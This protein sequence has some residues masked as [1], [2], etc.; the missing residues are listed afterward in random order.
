MFYKN[1]IFY[2]FLFI[3]ILLYFYYY[4]YSYD[5]IYDINNIN[6][7]INSRKKEII[8]V[9]NYD[10]T[11]YYNILN[12]DECNHIINYSKN[13]LTDSKVFMSD[14][15]EGSIATDIRISKNTFL[16]PNII[17]NN[18]LINT[19]NKLE[20][21]TSV[22]TNLPIVNQENIQVVKYDKNGYYNPHYDAC[23]SNDFDDKLNMNR[24]AGQRIYTFLVY[25]ND[26]FEGGNTFFPKINKNVKPVKGMG[27]L[28]KNINDDENY[29]ILSQHTGTVIKKGN[30]WVCNIWVHQNNFKNSH[31]VNLCYCPNCN[32]TNCYNV[33]KLKGITTCTLEHCININCPNY[34]KKNF[35]C[36]CPHCDNEYCKSK[37]R[38][39]CTKINCTNINCPK[40]K[41]NIKNNTPTN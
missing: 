15:N 30:K 38:K 16:D 23:E 26:D 25:L 3:I 13:H 33:A 18:N 34:F 40:G 21:I 19:I 4:Y 24:S 37:K 31:N 32:N 8:S 35:D 39:E 6:K 20:N 41:I 22:I 2:I 36:L 14:Y 5:T 17:D 10:I 1:I 29:H 11:L 28:F 7:F 9:K 12:D 27:I